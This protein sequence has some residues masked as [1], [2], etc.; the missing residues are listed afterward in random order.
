MYYSMSNTL[1]M[2]WKIMVLPQFAIKS[3][4]TSTQE[5]KKKTTKANIH[6]YTAIDVNNKIVRSE[7]IPTQQPQESK[8]KMQTTFKTFFSA[9]QVFSPKPNYVSIIYHITE[10]RSNKQLLSVISM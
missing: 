8:I 9:C 1:K 2:N 5:K 6:H 7:I 4:N 10:G 3:N